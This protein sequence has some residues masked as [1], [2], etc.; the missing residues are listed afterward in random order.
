M[1]GAHLGNL[2][3]TGSKEIE[4]VLFESGWNNGNW[5]NSSTLNNTNA[6]SGL[7]MD[8]ITIFGNTE[9]PM[10]LSG[11]STSLNRN[12]VERLNVTSKD[13]NFSVLNNINSLG[14]FNVYATKINFNDLENISVIKSGSI[15]T[16]SEY[17]WN[18]IPS[19]EY[20][21]FKIPL[22]ILGKAF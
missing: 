22:T 3:M 17:D 7:I 9:I 10:D 1:H 14:Q 21:N 5:G 19:E 11:L 12:R 6:L 4:L 8:Y 16:Y 2:T 13:F 20:E 15:N 18:S